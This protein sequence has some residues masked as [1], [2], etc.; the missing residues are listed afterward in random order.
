M[1]YLLDFLRWFHRLSY[2]LAILHTT[3]IVIKPSSFYK[4]LQHWTINQQQIRSGIQEYSHFLYNLATC[5][6]SFS[7]YF[8]FLKQIPSLR[9]T[10]QRKS[11]HFSFLHVE[12]IFNTSRMT[13]IAGGHRL[14]NLSL[15]C[16]LLLCLPFDSLPGLSNTCTNFN[17]NYVYRMHLSYNGVLLQS[18][19]SVMIVF[20]VA[21]YLI[22]EKEKDGINLEETSLLNNYY[23]SKLCH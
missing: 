14:S 22:P 21:M 6:R 13:G 2:K 1:A 4:H 18:Q 15:Y 8:N 10:M 16:Y 5:R 17:G 7:T 23:S 19:M 9:P 11:L 3:M 20:S 12:T